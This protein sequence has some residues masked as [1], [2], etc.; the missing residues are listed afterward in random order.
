MAQQSKDLFG[1][2]FYIGPISA[3]MLDSKRVRQINA[4]NQ[5]LSPGSDPV[6]AQDLTRIV[7]VAYVFGAM[8]RAEDDIIGMVTLNLNRKMTRPLFGALD[9]VVVSKEWQRHDITRLLIGE[10]HHFAYSSGCPYIE[11]TINHDHPDRQEAIEIYE[12]L[13]Y[14]ER[15]TNVYRC[16]LPKR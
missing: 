5:I 11:R 15:S 12:S 10:A 8:T 1:G 9:D 3:G 16:V 7:Q 2:L 14:K 13:G 6:S 4:L